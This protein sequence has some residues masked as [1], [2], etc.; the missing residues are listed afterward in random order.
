MVTRADLFIWTT[1]LLA[2]DLGNY[3][4]SLPEVSNRP[5]RAMI[6][7]I[8]YRPR[9]IS[10]GS[11]CGGEARLLFTFVYMYTFTISFFIG[12]L[13]CLLHHLFV[14]V[15]GAIWWW[16]TSVVF[17]VPFSL[18][19]PTLGG[20]LFFKI[21]TGSLDTNSDGWRTVA[22]SVYELPVLV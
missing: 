19:G 17:S 15:C 3:R 13:S 6:T 14:L 22:L 16:K 1:A 2:F 7:L 9:R 21:P 10:T 18:I 11:E 20:P 4:L 12:I 8:T 5:P